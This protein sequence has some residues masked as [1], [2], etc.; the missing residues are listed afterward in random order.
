MTNAHAA[1]GVWNQFPGIRKIR[2]SSLSHL[3][4]KTEFPSLPPRDSMLAEDLAATS[5]INCIGDGDRLQPVRVGIQ[6]YFERAA[7]LRETNFDGHSGPP[8]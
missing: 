7:R 1:T 3:L 8:V 6:H 2:Q 4:K 5:F